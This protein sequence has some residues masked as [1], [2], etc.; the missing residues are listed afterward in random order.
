MKAAGGKDWETWYS[1]TRD[2]LLVRRNKDGV[3]GD[4]KTSYFDTALALI[5]LP[6]AK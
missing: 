6:S 2:A 5:I 1:A 4:P 3:W